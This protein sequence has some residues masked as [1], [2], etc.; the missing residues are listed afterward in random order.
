M[1]NC[2][3]FQ[4]N[5]IKP[6]ERKTIIL[7][8]GDKKLEKR[9]TH[10]KRLQGFV[11]PARE[12]KQNFDFITF[13]DPHCAQITVLKMDFHAVLLSDCSKIE[14]DASI[15]FHFKLFEELTFYTSY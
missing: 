10:K 5:S 8:K 11:F 15:F 14:F 13:F 2:L 9:H 1:V 6:S 4:L 3:P 7:I 12:Q